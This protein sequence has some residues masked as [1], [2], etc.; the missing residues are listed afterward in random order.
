LKDYLSRIIL[1][2]KKGNKYEKKPLVAEAKQDVLSGPDAKF[3]NTHPYVIRIY[4][5]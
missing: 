5:Y 2:P 1:Y 3:Q 4:Y